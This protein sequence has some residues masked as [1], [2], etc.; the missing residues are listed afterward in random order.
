MYG[1][2]SELEDLTELNISS[3]TINSKEYEV[4]T[5]QQKMTNV[6]SVNGIEYD[7][8]QKAVQACGTTENTIT[9][10][11]DADPGA[12]MIIGENQ[13]ITIDLNGH[14]INNYTELQNKGILKI[15]DTSA[16]QS[17]KI[18]GLTGIAVSNIGTMELQSGSISDSGYGI[19]NIGTL[20]INGGNLTNNTYGI[21]NDINGIVNIES[22]TITSNTYG[23]YNYSSSS[24]ANINGGTI[25]LN[26]YGVYTYNGNTNISST[27]ISNNEYGIYVAGGTTTVKEGAEIQSNIG[28]YVASG[29][30]NIGKTGTM[31]SSS[32]VITGE[33][34]G[35]S[36]AGAGTVYMYDGQIK[37]KTGATQGFITY[38]ESGYA[39]A[40][41]K[42]GEYNI[43]YLALA[44]TIST[45]AQVNGIDFSNLQSAI[46]SVVGEE[47]Q[48]I[49]LT[50]GIITDTTFTI[51]EG[52]N[53]ILDMNEKTISSD[54]A[55]TINNAGNLTII[56]STSSGVA[57]I[58]STVGT[59]IV[60]SGT[61]T[62][63]QDD[64][65]VSQDI[66][67]IEGTTYGIE[68]TGTLNFYDGTIN[69]ASAVSGTIT[70]RPDGYVIRTTTVNSKERYYLS[71]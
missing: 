13:N 50:N 6:A 9:I 65:T 10:L 32:P 68:N 30:L 8:I 62:L 48:T 3:E 23:L 53:I 49:K 19:K 26:T 59:A 64:G 34:Y 2:I 43:D 12:T 42:E 14:R 36:V 38:T 1:I 21:Y 56:D 31:N 11:R 18:V 51:A 20:T 7:S 67:T 52:Q 33:T 71:I 58:S 46:N 61:L 69:G 28:A 5:L 24:N 15:K 35:L 4:L 66:I 41:K 40:N 55:I 37:G 16:E 45:V 25:N 63:G 70:N 47:V 44:G 60:N 22:G 17:G 54:L 57:K 27:G 29:R 39:V